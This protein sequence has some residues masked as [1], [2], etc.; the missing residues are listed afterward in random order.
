MDRAVYLRMDASEA[1][2][3]WF[4]ARRKI[5]AR[6]LQG[7]AAGRPRLS[8]L[9]AG[10]GT[11][12]NLSLLARYGRLDAFEYDK[13]ARALAAAKSGLP[14]AAG[15]L[16]DDL[17]FAG[18]RYDIIGL[19]DVLEHVEQDAAALAALA[20]R[21]NPGGA[22]VLTVP[23]FPALWSPHDVAHH[24][25][26]RYTRASLAEAAAR[27]GLVVE[28]S[29]YFNSLLLPLA[30]GVRALKRLSGNSS[31]DDARP[32]APLNWLLGTI[33][34]SERHLVGRVRLP[35]GLSLAAVLRPGA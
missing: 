21:L 34:A 9:E 4:V 29:F 6:V 7:V 32:P 24:H 31:A 15:A 30:A 25:H 19:F 18:A 8:L 17:P 22:I 13:E 26:R 23:A 12:G 3:W 20:N 11:G 28:Q 1:D 14:I 10:C 35:A 27:A 33:F 16:P 5:I 2:H